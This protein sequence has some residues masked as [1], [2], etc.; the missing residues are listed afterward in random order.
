[1]GALADDVG[2]SPRA[3]V[4]DV[5]RLSSVNAEAKVSPQHTK[6]Q[7][8]MDTPTRTKS[9]RHSTNDTHAVRDLH[10][11]WAADAFAFLK[12]RKSRASSAA[13]LDDT[14]AAVVDMQALQE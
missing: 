12:A 5:L 6:S 7:P 11:T 14:V 8:G 9:T 2:N 4:S 13:H 10:S 1:M 3:L